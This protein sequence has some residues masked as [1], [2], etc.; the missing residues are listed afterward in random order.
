MKKLLLTLTMFVGMLVA[1][2]GQ[3]SVY[4]CTTTG[5][6]ASCYNV[7]NPN[8]CAYEYCVYYGGVTPTCVASTYY[9][10]YGAIAV[11]YDSSGLRIIGVKLAGNSKYEV[12]Q[13]AR[14]ACYNAGALSNTISITYSWFDPY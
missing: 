5:A 11:G 13:A 2:Y 8:T 9:S 12:E 10:G 4:F 6:Y 1:S 3:S 14:Q 7:T